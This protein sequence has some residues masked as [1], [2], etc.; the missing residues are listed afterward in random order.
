M[1]VMISITESTKKKL[2]E[3]AKKNGLTVSAYITTLINKEK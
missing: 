3:L 1:K 2:D